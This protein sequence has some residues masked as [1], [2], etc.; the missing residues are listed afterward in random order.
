[1]WQCGIVL[2]PSSYRDSTM[3]Y[4]Y[5]IALYSLKK[6]R[7]KKSL[8]SKAPMPMAMLGHMLAMPLP[9][10]G[11]PFAL[12]DIWRHLGRSC[13]KAKK[14]QIAKRRVIPLLPQPQ[15]WATALPI[16]FTTAIILRVFLR[17]GAAAFFGPHRHGKVG[18]LHRWPHSHFAIALQR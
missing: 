6:A 4:I 17:L 11:A 13:F 12:C 18:C 16:A 10:G 8:A 3:Y 7:R 1:M 14:L 5:C 9:A 2:L 15:L